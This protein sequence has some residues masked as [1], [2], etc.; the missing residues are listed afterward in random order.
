MLKKLFSVRGALTIFLIFTTIFAVW[1]TYYKISVWGFSFKPT[2][3]SD[4]WT[5]DAHISFEPTGEPIEI[6]LSTP[7]ISKAYKILSEDTVAKGY[8]VQKDEQNHRIIMKSK[9]RKTKQNIYYRIML[10]DNAEGAGK[11]WEKAPQKPKKPRFEDDQQEGMINEIWALAEQKEGKSAAQKIIALLNEEALQPQVDAFLPV[12]KTQKIMAD[13]IIYL[14]SVKGIAARIVRGVKLSEKKRGM[15]ADLMLE[16]YEGSKWMLYNIETGASGLPKNFVIYQRGGVSLLD[17]SGG[18]NSSVKFS[19]VKSVISS[20]KMAGRRAKYEDSRL[21]N[22]TIYDLPSLEQNALKWLMIFP[23][24]ILLVVLLRNVVG[25]S[26]MGTF[27]PMLIA[28]SLVKTGFVSGF[29]CFSVIVALGL[30]IRTALTR[31][32]LLLVP[33]I[34]AV[35]ICVII[36]MQLLTTIGYQGDI[37]MI[38]S[39][40][41]FP[42]II[43]A[44]IIERACITWEE[45]GS[46]NAIKQIINT[47][48]V[49]VITYAVICNAYI[50]HI[51]FAFNEWNF[52]I[53]AIVMLL[54]TYTGYRL[55]EVKR[56]SSLVKGK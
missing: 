17:V 18:V 2:E 10:Y 46:R 34:S 16:V 8:E 55:S 32:N 41:F 51:M 6:S 54:G 21:F 14:L 20:F 11:I 27:T 9:P 25:I 35:V 44:W 30:L 52:V 12:K 31:L 45:D 15:N 1:A 3:K 36:I 29:I 7:S 13:K 23:L 22:W 28:M 40:A 19:V 5:V 38:A 47:L 50:R 56:F 49:A 53:L 42:I 48:L 43:T 39:A 24:G 4:V 26:T 37:R 33:R